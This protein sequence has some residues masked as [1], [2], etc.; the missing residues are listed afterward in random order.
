ME[1]DRPTNFNTYIWPICL[2]PADVDVEGKDAYIVG[3]GT[4]EFSGPTADI[5]QE[6]KVPIWSEDECRSAFV[7]PIS[8]RQFCAAG[9]NGGLDSCQVSTRVKV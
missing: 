2:P 3:W 5:L 6:I 4:T 1:L 9:R 8:A 7:Q